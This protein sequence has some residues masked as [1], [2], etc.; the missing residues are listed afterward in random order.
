[1]AGASRASAQGQDQFVVGISGGVSMPSG[2]GRTN[3]RAGPNGSVMLGIGSVDSPFGVRF[4]GTFTSLGR[5]TGPGTLGQ[6]AARVADFSANFL[7]NVLGES[8]RLYTVVGAG[9]YIYNPDGAGTTTTKDLAINGGLG[10]WLPWVNGFVEA[11]V[12]NMYRA[13]PDPATHLRGKRSLRIYPINFG[14][15]F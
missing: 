12:F 4:D 15:M 3:H 13:L 10:L 6:G 5:K 11:R 14:L 9:G 8:E 7:F 1:M 2:I